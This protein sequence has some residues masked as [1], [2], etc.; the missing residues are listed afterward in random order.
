MDVLEAL[1]TT[2]AMRRVKD[3]PIPDDVVALILDAAVRAP[4]GG[5]QQNWQFLWVDDPEVRGKLAPIYRECIDMLWQH[6]YGG[7]IEAAK[8]QPDLPESKQFMRI[9]SSVEHAANNFA[10]YPGLLFAFAQHDPSGGSI[11]PAVWSAMLAARSQ[12]VGGTLT[13][14]FMFKGPQVLELLGVPEDQGW[15][16]SGCV[17]FGYPTGRWGIAE[18][19][20]AESVSHRNRWGTPLGI[21]V[22]GPRWSPST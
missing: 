21:D 5:N 16:M 11:Y 15:I 22:N 19:A 20:P 18:R 17:T 3:E 12:G 6:V 8:A 9:V 13:S 2:R 10:T 14:V 4:S 7:R 1:Y